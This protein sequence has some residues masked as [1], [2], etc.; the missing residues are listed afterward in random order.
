[1]SRR[2]SEPKHSPA[3]I[4]AALNRVYLTTGKCGRDHYELHRYPSEPSANA[5]WYRADGWNNLLAANGV[6]VG[7]PARKGSGRKPSPKELLADLVP[8]ETPKERRCLSCRTLI[9]S[10][11][12]TCDGCRGRNSQHRGQEEWAECM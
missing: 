8:I 10:V 1:M 3:E 4:K 7:R 9:V 11:N 2:R 5:M 12:Y 6:P